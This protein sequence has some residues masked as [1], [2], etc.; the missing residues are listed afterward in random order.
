MNK[1][2]F[3]QKIAIPL[4]GLGILLS[5][6]AY[7]PILRAGLGIDAFISKSFLTVLIYL[8]GGYMAGIAGL[9]TWHRS[10]AIKPVNY[11]KSS[12]EYLRKPH[13]L[14]LSFLIPIPFISCLLL[15]WFWQKDRQFSPQ[16]DE[17]YRETSNFHLSLHLYLLVSFFLMP[18]FIGFVMLAL[19]VATYLTATI[20]HILRSPTVET[21]SHY[22]IN[23]QIA[24]SPSQ[25]Q[26][27]P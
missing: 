27:T 7:I 24:L 14:G 25:A 8:I 11:K 10:I 17:S 3:I 1:A 20:Y 4:I 6:F 19:L 18:L 9:I 12:P 13:L 5:S 16:L 15:G 21:A 2:T 26:E 23:I 22:P